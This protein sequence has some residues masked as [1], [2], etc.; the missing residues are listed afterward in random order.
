MKKIFDYFQFL[1]GKIKTYHIFMNQKIYIG[2]LIFVCAS[3]VKRLISKFSDE[4]ILPFIK[5]QE[6]KS[7]IYDFIAHILNVYVCTF[8]LYILIEEID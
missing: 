5:G 3:L 8:I 7:G 2:A 1:N 6:L 4:I